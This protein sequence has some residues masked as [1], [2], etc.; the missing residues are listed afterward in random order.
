MFSQLKTPRP[1]SP[2]EKTDD[3][4]I[5]LLAEDLF[6]SDSEEE[7]VVSLPPLSITIP[8]S[9]TSS[10]LLSPIS[11]QSSSPSPVSLSSSTVSLSTSTVS[12]TSIKTPNS[13]PYKARFP[14]RLGKDFFQSVPSRAAVN[15]RASRD[16][17]QRKRKPFEIPTPDIAPKRY[18]S[19]PPKRYSP[20]FARFNPGLVCGDVKIGLNTP[21]SITINNYYYNNNQKGSQV[22]DPKLMSRG[23]FKRYCKRAT[24]EEISKA[25][26]LR[27][28]NS[29]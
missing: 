14:S 13:I 4:T 3:D 27:K 24:P 15:R 8:N 19:P 9:I 28:K 6:V 29:K 10:S 23:Q 5:S 7:S 11:L 25:L 2:I 21:H 18:K 1:I 22:T 26:I 17:S 20:T 12:T 16:F